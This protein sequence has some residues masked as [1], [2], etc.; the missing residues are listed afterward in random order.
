MEPWSNH[1]PLYFFEEEAH[2][3]GYSPA[4]HTDSSTHP[5]RSWKQINTH[6]TYILHAASPTWCR[7]RG[8]LLWLFAAVSCHALI[9]CRL[10]M[11]RQLLRA[12]S[13]FATQR[14]S[15]CTLSVNRVFRSTWWHGFK[16][17]LI[18]PAAKVQEQFQIHVACSL[19]YLLVRRFAGSQWPI[20]ERRTL[21][22]SISLRW[23]IDV[24]WFLIAHLRDSQSHSVDLNT[25]AGFLFD[26]KKKTHAGFSLFHRKRSTAISRCVEDN[27][28]SFNAHT[29][30]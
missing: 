7:Q 16:L 2:F 28:E 29:L 12:L 1:T 13:L 6:H 21:H 18:R 4:L 26:L 24:S 11:S 5:Q 25:F 15:I 19:F 20:C 8:K 30:F 17:L 23:V 3:A 10:F 22:V 9:V 14:G 27:E